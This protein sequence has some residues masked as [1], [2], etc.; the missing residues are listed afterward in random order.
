[1]VVCDGA[2]DAWRGEGKVR[3]RGKDFDVSGESAAWAPDGLWVRGDLAQPRLGQFRILAPMVCIDRAKNKAWVAGPGAIRVDGL[4]NLQGASAST[5]FWPRHCRKG[6]CTSE[7]IG[8]A[9]SRR[10]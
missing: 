6:P 2:I 1:M 7:A 9:C 3:A 5:R 10:G 4:P 8:Y